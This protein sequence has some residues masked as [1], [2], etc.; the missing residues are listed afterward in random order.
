MGSNGLYGLEEKAATH[1]QAA[2]T[3]WARQTQDVFTG[4]H[5][6]AD[7]DGREP[8]SPEV[9]GQD[10]THER[11]AGLAGAPVLPVKA[12]DSI[13]TR[14]APSMQIHGL[15]VVCLQDGP[16]PL[17][18]VPGQAQ[19]ARSGRRELLDDRLRKHPCTAAVL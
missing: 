16:A 11:Q 15:Q 8:G 13:F 4:W 10:G 12:C 2:R 9:P 5:S 7:M 6:S 19:H 1:L 17:M 18:E 3:E 14:H